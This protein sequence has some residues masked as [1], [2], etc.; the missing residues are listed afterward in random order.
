MVDWSL[1]I[2]VRDK[3]RPKR[4]LKKDETNKHMLG[5]KTKA[6]QKI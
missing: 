3:G 4:Y 5:G 1:L 2:D 6:S